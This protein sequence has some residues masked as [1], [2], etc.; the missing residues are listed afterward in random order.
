[1]AEIPRLVPPA[2][3]ACAE[4]HGRFASAFAPRFFTGLILGLV[5]LGPAWWDARFLYGMAVWDALM[6]VAWYVDRR[7]L[8]E[9]REIT[10]ARIWFEPLSQGAESPVAIELSQTGAIPI[11]VSLE[12]DVPASLSTQLPAVSARVPAQRVRSLERS[13]EDTPSRATYSV[14]PTARGDVRIGRVSLRYQGPLKL[15][16]RWASAALEQTVRVYPNFQEAK[17]QTFY[18]MRSRQIE[19]EKRFKR[20]PGMGR[21]FESLRDY[22]PGDEVR[23]ICWTATARRAK[24]ISKVYRPER[25]QTVIIV[26]DDGRLM[27]ARVNPEPS[28][29]SSSPIALTKLD[30]A[31]TAALSLAQVALYSGD[32]VGLLAY[33]RK[34]HARL[35]AARGSS[36]LRA[37]VEQLAS[38]KG[39]LL[40]ADHARAADLLLAGQKRRS[41]LVWLT[42]LA[43]TAATPEVIESASRLLK[44]HLVLFVAIGQPELPRLLAERPASVGAMY[45]YVAAAEMVQ[46]RELL[47]RQ[48]RQQGALTAELLP[49]KLASGIVNQYL[50]IKERSL[51]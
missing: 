32:S 18:L 11:D 38:V 7:R 49:G 24:P 42:D 50:E 8:P 2:V 35:S 9:P 22:R 26:V 46:R 3:T 51:L 17:R 6:L 1:M 5:W 25:S 23:D 45:R 48:L 47:L 31:V 41:L 21:E 19:L 16:E 20:Q 43:E 15:A 33:G 34:T 28:H 37:F 14:R 13:A 30:Y 4:S 27:L 10:V 29:E 36:H 44:R 40:E 39:E 12:D